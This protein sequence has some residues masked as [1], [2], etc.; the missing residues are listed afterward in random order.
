MTRK[1]VFS[2]E[3][4]HWNDEE[5]YIRSWVILSEK[6]Y[7]LLKDKIGLCKKLNNVKSEIKFGEGHDYSVFEDLQF[8]VYFTLTFCNDF[9]KRSFSIINKITSQDNSNFSINGRE[10]K[11]K[12]LNT[13]KNSL[14]LN[15]YEFFHIKNTLSFIKNKFPHD[16][17][18]FFIDSPQ[19]Q[20]NDWK[21]I[22]QELN[23]E[24][25][26]ISI[27]NRSEEECGIQFADIIVGNI[28][29]ILKDIDKYLSG[30]K[31]LNDFD[32]KI[33]SN[34]SQNNGISSA[35]L[36]NPQVIMWD[37]KYQPII[38]KIIKLMEIKND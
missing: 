35:F 19:C 3:T 16:S 30:S 25:F 12:I 15:I 26:K 18:I 5:F 38:N 9:K 36:N 22:F 20:N 37:K 8:N 32:K 13:L 11:D 31:K 28:R 21:D 24:R 34:F 23:K 33:I 10:I 17:F 29:K 2:D 1:F 27:I 7:Y 14:F 4:G 6:E